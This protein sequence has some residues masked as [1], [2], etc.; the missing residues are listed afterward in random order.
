MNENKRRNLFTY[1][2]KELS[3]D[4]FLCWLFANYNCENGKVREVSLSLLSEFANA[5]IVDKITN[6][7]ISKQW[8][9]IDIL[10]ELECVDKTYFIAIEDKTYSFEHD[11][12][13]EKYGNE[14]NKYAEEQKV[15]SNKDIQCSYVFYKTAFMREDEKQNI[16]G[17]WTIYDIQA[18]H[19]FFCEYS[20]TNNAILDD[21]IAYINDL[22][23]LLYNYKSIE[24]D[25]LIG[26]NHVFERYCNDDL[27][28][29]ADK[30]E[31]TQYTSIYQG[32]YTAT[33]LQKLTKAGLRIELAL[34]FRENAFSAWIKCWENDKKHNDVNYD[35]RSEIAAKLES[36]KDK[37]L[38]FKDHSIHRNRMLRT[39]INPRKFN[40][41]S[42]FDNW[43]N[44][45]LDDFYTAID[46]LQEI[47]S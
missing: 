5:R 39:I 26:N 13:L 30:A 10:V 20:T 6:C 35:I 31:I 2:T 7:K 45:C 33:Y 4:A 25:E 22:Y 17:D 41:F 28:K 8:K 24:F 38:V 19:R 3:Q 15:K 46:L 44:K 40:D 36:N 34:F 37:L 43:I 14:L 12:Q 1:A 16:S 27:A 21:Y 32:K 11:D 29:K 23:N 9:Y 47:K 18:I 42:A